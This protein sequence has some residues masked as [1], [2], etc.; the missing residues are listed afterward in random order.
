MLC[1]TD[2]GHFPA[3]LDFRTTPPDP[4]LQPTYS[5]RFD[6]N[7]YNI[8]QEEENYA[9]FQ[10]WTAEPGFPRFLVLQVQHPTP[11]TLIC[12]QNPSIC[13]SAQRCAS[14][15]AGADIRAI[16]LCCL[17]F[18]DSYAVNSASQGPW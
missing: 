3:D 12:P 9:F 5:A 2:H 4:T 11:C 18:D 14:P 13:L 10:R 16:C 7:G 15:T 17:D 1:Q 6:I 8:L